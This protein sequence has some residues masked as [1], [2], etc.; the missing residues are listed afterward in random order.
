M[1]CGQ[2]DGSERKALYRNDGDEGT[3]DACL[4]VY[5]TSVC[6]SRRAVVEWAER[7]EGAQDCVGIRSK[8]ATL[9]CYWT[10]FG[11]GLTSS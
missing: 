9:G 11:S 3:M 1:G 5:Y 7:G 8:R 6:A 2:D 4:G 10:T